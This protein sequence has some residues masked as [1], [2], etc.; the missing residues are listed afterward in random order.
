M[1]LDVLARKANIPYLEYNCMP[2][3]ELSDF[4]DL[5][6]ESEGHGYTVNK[7]QKEYIPEVR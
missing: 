5:F 7:L 4:I 6:A 3:G 1:R 2:I